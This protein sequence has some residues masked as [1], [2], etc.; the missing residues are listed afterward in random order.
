M[1]IQK[2]TTEYYYFKIP[3]NP[4]GQ[5]R[6]FGVRL[7]TLI[8]NLKLYFSLLQKKPSEE[9]YD[10]KV[11]SK[12]KNIN[13]IHS[14]VKESVLFQNVNSPYIYVGVEGI[15]YSVFDLQ[16][17]TDNM[18]VEFSERIDPETILKRTITDKEFYETKEDK[19]VFFK[20]FYFVPEEEYQSSEKFTIHLNT[21]VYGLEICVQLNGKDFDYNKKCDLS[22]LTGSLSVPKGSWKAFS[23]LIRK[24][25]SQ[26]QV[27][28]NFPIEFDIHISSDFKFAIVSLHQPGKV[29][30]SKI[31]PEATLIYQINLSKMN[32][33]F[34][35]LFQTEVSSIHAEIYGNRNQTSMIGSFDRNLFGYQEFQGI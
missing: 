7:V 26:N 1:T 6:K 21:Q 24:N 12:S 30:N 18:V 15:S 34:I 14:I 23:F 16:V 31:E 28:H 10:I 32:Y 13:E 11:E 5:Q 19:Y 35:V 22:S 33:S 2:Q 20:S 29:H 25:T 9:D 8:G 17:L 27:F 3:E 4:D